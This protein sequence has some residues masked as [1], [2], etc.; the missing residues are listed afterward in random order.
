MTKT[1][2]P[3]AK[4]VYSSEPGKEHAKKIADALGAIIGGKVEVEKMPN[5][6]TE[7]DK[8]AQLP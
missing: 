4:V 6:E 5:V 2:E 8:P 1:T 7:K 3:T